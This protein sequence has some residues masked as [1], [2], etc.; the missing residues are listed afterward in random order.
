M[1]DFGLAVWSHHLRD[2][3]SEDE[4]PERVARLAD[5]GFDIV[6][7]CVK[8]PPGLADFRTDVA[9]VAPDYPEWDPLRKLI[10]AC[11]EHGMEVHA[12]FCVFAEGEKSRL[13]IEHPE[14][15]GEVQE[16]PKWV[17]GCRP[18][19]Q[20]YL[21]A[22]YRSV[23]EGYQPA[24]LH[25]DYMRT[26][27]ACTCEYCRAQMAAQGIDVTDL[28]TGTREHEAWIDWR[29][30]R[31]ADFVRSMR[32]LT[33]ELGLK[34]SAAVFSGYPECIAPQAQDW[35]LWAE[36][37]LVDLLMPMN[38]TQSTRVAVMRTKAHMAQVARKVPVW[39]G[40]CKRASRFSNCTPEELGE[41]MEA[42]LAEGPEG[43]TVFSYGSL[44]PEDLAVIR[45][46]KGR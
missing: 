29:V 40:L 16:R 3:G 13:V 4:L 17:C 20:D 5:A 30:G 15:K 10:D 2:F 39:E 12:W 19:V 43:L 46:I 35:V 24:G 14:Y 22:L 8:N 18:E 41:Q 37:G 38:Y 25:L 1:A 7:P 21:L 23:A 44:T 45:A 42:V 11:D 36:E 28:K 33:N 27:G 32:G 26:G 9:D 31:V 6:I 34:L